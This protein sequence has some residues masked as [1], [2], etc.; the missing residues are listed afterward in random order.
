M[1][2]PLLKTVIGLRKR[3]A[4]V[5]D[6]VG[7]ARQPGKGTSP[8]RRQLRAQTKPL[9]CGPDFLAKD[10]A[11]SFRSWRE[12]EHLAVKPN[13]SSCSEVLKINVM[14]NGRGVAQS[15]PW[16]SLSPLVK[17]QPEEHK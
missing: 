4:A 12:E 9:A 6:L 3:H 16:G 10:Y 17:T 14:N 11:F 8:W 7:R 5:D 2:G 15:I 13:A 1:L